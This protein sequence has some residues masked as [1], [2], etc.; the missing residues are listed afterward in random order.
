[1]T[2]KKGPNERWKTTDMAT[3]NKVT[4]GPKES[5]IPRFE[6]SIHGDVMRKGHGHILRQINHKN[7]KFYM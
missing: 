1:M 3:L 5:D 6:T 4:T 7:H 2:P